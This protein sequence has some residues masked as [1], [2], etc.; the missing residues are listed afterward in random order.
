MKSEDNQIELLKDKKGELSRRIGVAKSQGECVQALIEQMRAV[1]GKI[2]EIESATNNSVKKV[3]E[4][5]STDSLRRTADPAFLFK[6]YATSPATQYEITLAG[7]EMSHLWE[8]YVEQKSNSFAYHSWKFKEVIESSFGH[9]CYYLAA[10]NTA[11]TV[12][13][14]L[15]VVQ[16]RSRL[17][18]NYFTSLP[19]FNYGGPLADSV[20]IENALLSKAIDL[21]QRE[22]AQHLEL[23]DVAPREDWPQKGSKVSMILPL[24]D[25][26]DGLFNQVGSKV[27]AQIRKSEKFCLEFRYG[28]TE[29][30]D[31]F[32]KV[33][34]RNMRDLGTPV[35]SKRF[36]FNLINACD[37]QR[38]H[39]CV[40]Y[41]DNLPVSGAILLGHKGVL[42]IPWASTLKE[43]NAMNANMFLYWN[44]LK[45]AIERNYDFF[46][47]GRSSKD[48]GTY[49]FKKQ[50]GAKP[51]Q[52]YWHYWLPD[53]GELPELN[54]N[55]PKFNL[56]IAIWKKL[57]VWVS[58]MIGPV[59]VKNLP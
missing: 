35:Y 32:Y 23:R 49:K 43:A 12:C 19:F 26:S 55:N 7:E 1:T 53:G 10:V 42:E 14:I 27:R 28:S 22:N 11:G 24:P 4:T 29:L 15:P 13:G 18:G 46:D 30:L 52:L 25:S 9:P 31:D 8:S 45:L 39:V 20:E 56:L 51:V 37:E 59:V 58:V 5:N 50:W 47:F 21:V 33:F 16:T 38:A 36:F 3:Q 41:F 48:A 34:A 6:S 2:K 44:V 57:P 54:P 40:V 17:F